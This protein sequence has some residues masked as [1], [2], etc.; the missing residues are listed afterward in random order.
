MKL[1]SKLKDYNNLLEEILDKK[2]FPSLSKNLLF[3]MIYKLEISYK[4]YEKVKV[5]SLSKDEFLKNILEVIKN[6]CDNI[7]TVEPESINASLLIKH[8]VDAVS[9]CKERS[10]MCYPTEQAMLYAIA[11]IEPKYFYIKNDFLYKDIFQEVLV[12]GYKQNTMEILKNFNG[13]SWDVGNY[14][15]S[16]Y[17]YNL[18]YQNIFIIM[19]EHFLFD[20]RTDNLGKRDYLAEM[21]RYIKA[22]TGNDNY[23]LSLCKMLYLL[24]KGK[25]KKKITNVLEENSIKYKEYLKKDDDF[26]KK[27]IRQINKLKSYY[28][29]LNNK[30]SIYE[31]L[32]E[33]QKYF[34][35]FIMKKNNNISDKEEILNLI[36][37]LRYYQNI[38]LSENNLIKDEPNI[39]KALDVCLKAVVTNA[40]KYKVLKMISININDNFEILKYILDTRIIDLEDLR[41]YIEC[42]SNEIFLK[43]YDKE[44]FEKQGR[45]EFSGSPKDIV[46]KKKKNVKLFS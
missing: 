36:Y 3:S 23:Y 7:K 25:N 15:K 4:D 44:V 2:T 22:V 18:I 6:Y 28:E 33:L 41:F 14:R 1:F 39:V 13:W 8:D 27:N 35:H 26:K 38:R 46:I 11:D 45:K 37:V 34:L 9:N 40:C 43:V 32:I 29:V 42:E 24:S 5:N 31:E 17:I 10:I 16:D 20:W 21:K 12:D 30:N 19:G